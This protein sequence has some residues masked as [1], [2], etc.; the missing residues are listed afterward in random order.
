MFI[1]L[2]ELSQKIK[3]RS[4]KYKLGADGAELGKRRRVQCVVHGRSP[5]AVRCGRCA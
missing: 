5:G 4:S 3:L 2:I 1:R